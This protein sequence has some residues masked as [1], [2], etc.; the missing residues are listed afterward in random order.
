MLLRRWMWIVWPAF[1]AAAAMEMLVFA[2]V[3]PLE[4]QWLQVQ[5]FEVTRLGVYTAAF[6]LFWL[7]AMVA[8]AMTSLLTLPSQELNAK[9][10]N[11]HS[12]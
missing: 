5:S 7:I 11:S 3:D 1:L 8:S 9:V 12:G 10:V 4:L 2:F 6:F